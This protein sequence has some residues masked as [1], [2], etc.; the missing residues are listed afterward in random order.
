MGTPA[1]MAHPMTLRAAGFTST[2]PAISTV[3]TVSF[4][5]AWRRTNPA[6]SG[7]AQMLTSTV[8]TPARRSWRRSAPQNGQPGRE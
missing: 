2:V 4:P 5:R 8:G 7:S 1:S 6:A 3:G